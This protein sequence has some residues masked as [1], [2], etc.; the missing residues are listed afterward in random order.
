MTGL[1]QIYLT[2]LSRNER[3]K[4]LYASLGF[5]IFAREPEAVNFDG[6]FAD[7]YQMLLFL[8]VRNHLY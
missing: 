6:L 1:R 3:A 7:E 2:V 5:Q 8:N 4:N